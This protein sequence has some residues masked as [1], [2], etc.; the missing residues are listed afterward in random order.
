[1]NKK[2]FISTIS[3]VIL[4]MGCAHLPIRSISRQETQVVLDDFQVRLGDKY[5]ILSSV[6]F[7][8]KFFTLSSLGLTSIDLP[9][10]Y[11][12]VA[13][14]T[15]AGITLFKIVSEKG[16][17]IHSFVIPELEKRGDVAKAVSGNIR[18]IYF[19]LTPGQ[20]IS[21]VSKGDKLYLKTL[22]SDGAQNEYVFSE[23]DRTLLEKRL[24]KNGKLSWNIYYKNWFADSSGK[25]H[26]KDIRLLHREYKYQLLLNLK[27]AKPL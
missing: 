10:D 23:K 17:I 6:V 27:E 20:L 18:D 1:M 14:I 22:V 24:Y 9:K 8:Y 21:M 26:P 13:G 4:L 19:D 12:A 7:K 15:P 25:I 11:L 2:L 3:L 5:E 16:K